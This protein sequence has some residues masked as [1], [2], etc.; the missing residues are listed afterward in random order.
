MTASNRTCNQVGSCC[1]KRKIDEEAAGL[2]VIRASSIISASSCVGQRLPNT[3]T[4]CSLSTL[5][6]GEG[7]L[8]Q[9]ELLE[10]GVGLVLVQMRDGGEAQ[11]DDLL[12]EGSDSKVEPVPLLVHVLSPEA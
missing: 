4:K 12:A 1:R 10:L 2:L 7:V 9:E 6:F 5:I 11:L 3:P 8:L